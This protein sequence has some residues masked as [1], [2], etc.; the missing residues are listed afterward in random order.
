[1]LRKTN[2]SD[3]M[4]KIDRRLFLIG[5]LVILFSIGIYVEKNFAGIMLIVSLIIFGLVAVIWKEQN[6]RL[7]ALGA[8]IILSLVAIGIN[9]L[10]FGIDF[11]GGVR[12][13]VVL[14]KSVDQTTMNEIV[15]TVKKRANFLALSETRV[16]AIG[17]SIIYVELPKADE[18]EIQKI[19]QILTQQGVFAGVVD[20]ETALSGEDIYR[21]SIRPVAEPGQ[22]W[23]V[24]FRLTTSGAQAFAQAVKGKANKPLYMFID[25]PTDAAI[26][27]SIE[28][29]RKRGPGD[30]TDKEIIDAARDALSL[31]ENTIELHILD[32]VNATSAPKTNKTKAIIS[33]NLDPKIKAKINERGFI[34]QELDDELLQPTMVRAANSISVERW[35]AVG[36]LSSP[37]LSPS[38]TQGE[39]NYLG[40][41]IGGSFDRNL[42]QQ[43]RAK[44]ANEEIKRIDS[45][46][47]GGALP[48]QITLGSKNEIPATLGNEALKIS[49]IG[50]AASL[51]FISLLVA[52]RYKSPRII[53]PIIVTSIGELIILL[54]I[55]GSFAIDLPA[56]AGIIAAIGAGVDSQIVITDEIL[57]R[58]KEKINE[59]I[60]IAF[61]II[62]MNVLVAIFA[63]LPLLF[64]GI[65]EVTSFAIST[66]LGALLGFM[67]SRPAYAILAEKILEK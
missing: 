64:S 28:D 51:F 57:K 19:E 12:I 16:R 67:I 9:G 34:L 44:R 15:D 27:I 56:I 25:R 7:A 49:L 3:R 50:I 2:I 6:I 48:V 38:V 11:N 29:L 32:E 41:S 18:T 24:T 30:A 45:I 33:K 54:A 14:E 42:D 53:I 46:L 52:F 60:E 13:P 20:K 31:G 10:K 63:M 66:I 43:T 35:E 59:S 8:L 39:V 55:L 22:D 26:F 65:T 58:S 62:K 47:K 4:E 40:Y 17:D 37:N 61:G 1:M 36:L 5:I 23:T 21:D